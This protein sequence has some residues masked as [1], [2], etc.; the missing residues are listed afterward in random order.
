[1][2]TYKIRMKGKYSFVLNSVT[3]I[4]FVTRWF[5][6]HNMTIKGGDDSKLCQNYVDD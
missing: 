2:G 5:K 3:M 4:N 1:M 6:L